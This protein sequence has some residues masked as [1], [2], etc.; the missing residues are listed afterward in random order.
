METNDHLTL[1]WKNNLKFNSRQ[2]AALK[3]LYVW[4]DYLARNEDESTGYVLPNN[5]LLKICEILPREKQGILALLNP[6]P[7]LVRQCINE[8]HKIILEARSKALDEGDQESQQK[9]WTA[10]KGVNNSIDL[11]VDRRV[12]DAQ[13]EHSHAVGQVP[14]LNW[15][16][17]RGKFE[18]GSVNGKKEAK[19]EDMKVVK[20]SSG[21]WTLSDMFIGNV[22]VFIAQ[23]TELRQKKNKVDQLFADY[24]SPYQN[25]SCSVRSLSCE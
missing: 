23:E 5:L 16:E 3:E 12:D 15:N 2:L 22:A 25:V 20:S 9:N 8:I 10:V 21:R 17:E 7:P 4:R 14:L 13:L 11:T 1:L 6:I 24:V 19:E 18:F